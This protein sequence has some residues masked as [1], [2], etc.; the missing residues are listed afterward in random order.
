MRRRPKRPPT[1]SALTAIVIAALLSGGLVAYASQQLDVSRSK[2]NRV[3]RNSYMV[4]ASLGQGSLS[5]GRPQQLSVKLFNR[6]GHSLW[7]YQLTISGELDA[8]HTAAGCSLARDFRFTQLPKKSFP[9]RIPKKRMNVDKVRVKVKGKT[10]TKRRK[11]MVWTKLS[12]KQNRG[13]PTLELVNLPTTNQ[14]AC[15]GA[16]VTFKIKSRAERT[17]KAAKKHLRSKK[18]KKKG[19]AK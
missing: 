14:D 11:R 2:K 7:V 4:Q 10:K 19:A 3:V 1:R 13:Q 5:I 16:T 17:K 12:K 18:S 8:A 9:F 15:K 6:K